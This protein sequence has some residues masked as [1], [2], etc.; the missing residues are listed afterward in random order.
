MIQYLLIE[1]CLLYTSNTATD[2]K[3]YMVYEVD[4]NNAKLAST[5]GEDTI[6]VKK[7]ECYKSVDNEPVKITGDIVDFKYPQGWTLSTGSDR[8]R[9]EG[10]IAAIRT[11]KNIESENRYATPDEQL[12]L[13]HYVGWGGLSNAF[14]K[15]RWSEEYDILKDLLTDSEYKAARASVTDSFYTPPEV[16]KMC[17]RDRLL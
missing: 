10:N 9:F 11:L 16:I 1:A 14:D 4:D 12:I 7:N 13:S 2:D 15:S 6:T 8:A 3:D 5:D 17:I